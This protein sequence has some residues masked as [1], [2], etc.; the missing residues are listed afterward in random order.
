MSDVL[1][2]NVTEYWQENPAT[3]PNVEVLVQNMTWQALQK[4]VAGGAVPTDTLRGLKPMQQGKLNLDEKKR[5]YDFWTSG[6]SFAELTPTRMTLADA[7]EAPSASR[8]PVEK[9]DVQYQR[10]L[11]HAQAFADGERIRNP[12]KMAQ[13]DAQ[14]RYQLWV[15]PS[16]GAEIGE[17]Q[18]FIRSRTGRTRVNSYLH[19]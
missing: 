3:R 13:H 6:D 11:P 17:D 14:P 12:P 9:H 7:R 18:R 8:T 5:R 2:N 10:W 19:K 16:S 15:P 1:W 4:P